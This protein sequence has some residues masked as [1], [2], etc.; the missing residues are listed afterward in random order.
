[1]FDNIN[2]KKIC[3]VL[4]VIAAVTLPV[5]I[6]GF[7][8]IISHTNITS[9][10]INKEKNIPIK[11]ISEIYIESQTVSMNIIPTDSSDLKVHLYGNYRGSEE[12]LKN[13]NLDTRVDDGKIYVQ[14]V[15]PRWH[16]NLLPIQMEMK[17]D[18]YLPKSYAENLKFENSTGAIRGGDFK[19]K[20]FICKASTGSINLGKVEANEVNIKTS[21]SSIKANEIIGASEITSGTG[22]IDIGRLSGKHPIIKDNTGSINIDE[23]TGDSEASTSTGTIRIGKITGNIEASTGTGSINVDEL[24]ASDSRIKS[25]TGS[26]KVHNM[27]GN[28]VIKGGTTSVW[29]DYA[30]FNNNSIDIQTNTGRIDLG[31][32]KESKFYLDAKT[33]TGSVNCEFPVTINNTDDNKRSLQGSVA[34]GTSKVFLRTGTSSISVH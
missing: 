19:A 28:T 18:I 1:M 5:S 25:N 13:Y 12:S 2:I 24:R 6:V 14:T 26:I 9:S 4:T 23:I 29:V 22:S 33:N 3:I 20:E 10:N 11:G 21:T 16:I 30:E 31:L 34:G 15:E 8:D 32:P 7:A 27:T 17:L